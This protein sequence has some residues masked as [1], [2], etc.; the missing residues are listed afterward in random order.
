MSQG[1]T[2]ICVFYCDGGG[3]WS[4]AALLWGILAPVMVVGEKGF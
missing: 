1:A 2:L 4:P 3:H